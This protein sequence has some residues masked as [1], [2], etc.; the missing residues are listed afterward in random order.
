MVEDLP[1]KPFI[2]LKLTWNSLFDMEKNWLEKLSY[3]FF[4][5]LLNLCVTN[6]GYFHTAIGFAVSV[7]FPRP[8]TL[9]NRNS[10]FN[11]FPWNLF[12]WN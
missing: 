3:N 6:D 11:E 10:F 2:L 4:S 9:D 8:V 5:K 1:F 12:I 7:F